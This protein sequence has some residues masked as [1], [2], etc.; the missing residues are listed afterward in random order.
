MLSHIIDDG[1]LFNFVAS[2]GYLPIICK[3]FSSVFSQSIFFNSSLH[4][5]KAGVFL[6]ERN[7]LYCKI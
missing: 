2:P 6:E 7:A 1:L 5:K 4:N 3:M